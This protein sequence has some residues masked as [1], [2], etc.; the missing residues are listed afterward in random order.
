MVWI[1]CHKSGVAGVEDSLQSLLM[2]RKAFMPA[3]SL[4]LAVLPS[5]CPTERHLFLGLDRVGLR[6]DRVSGSLLQCVYCAH[7]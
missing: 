5:W 2:S 4:A 6:D 3:L 7:S 1:T